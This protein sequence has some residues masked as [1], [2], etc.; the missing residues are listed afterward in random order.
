MINNK[1]MAAALHVLI[2]FIHFTGVASLES[3]SWFDS[4]DFQL[5]AKSLFQQSIVNREGIKNLKDTFA[6][7]SPLIFAIQSFWIAIILRR[8]ITT[9]E[10]FRRATP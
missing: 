2:S 10:A 4:P 9:L 1:I 6:Y 8:I 5:K 7:L 3:S